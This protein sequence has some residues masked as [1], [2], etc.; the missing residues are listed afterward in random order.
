MRVPLAVSVAILALASAHAVAGTETSYRG[1]VQARQSDA[2]PRFSGQI[3]RVNVHDNQVVAQ[4]D[5]VVELDDRE[6][7]AHVAAAQAQL[8]ASRAQLQATEAAVETTP[9][10]RLE[11]AKA[12][13]ALARARVSAAEAELELARID[14]QHTTI[15]AEIRGM[16]TLHGIAPGQSVQRGQ[17]LAT[18]VDLDGVWVDAFFTETQA[19]TIELG[20]DVEVTI[21]TPA[22]TV[23]LH[24]KVDDVNRDDAAFTQALVDTGALG[25]ARVGVGVKI[26][27]DNYQ[28]D[29]SLRPGMW[30]S[31]TI[32]TRR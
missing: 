19:A 25:P 5:V 13:L 30:A 22:H 28:R 1:E 6:P 31:A 2:S 18:I 3:K 26:R 32:H 24:G 16:V 4:G 10:N 9:A 14:L 7:R 11:I 8:E 20:Q 21:S 17:S 29:R 23:A 15:T 27:L 12:T